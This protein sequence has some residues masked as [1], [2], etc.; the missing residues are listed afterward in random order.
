MAQV[1]SPLLLDGTG[2]SMLTKL[3]GIRAALAADVTIATTAVAGIVKP[4]GVSIS[5]EQDGTISA[6]IPEVALATTAAPGI[7]KPDGTTITVAADGTIVSPLQPTP[8][9][10]EVT[11]AASGWA[12]KVYSFES[13]YPSANY[14]ILGIYPDENT[15]DAQRKAWI[16]ADCGG[17]RATN[18]IYAHGTVPTIDMVLMVVVIHK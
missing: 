11:V 14:D 10:V 17:Y 1:T 9:N 3:E 13:A 18:T 15:T 7:V 6:D 12:N 2:Q 4:D 8:T 5:V 16:A